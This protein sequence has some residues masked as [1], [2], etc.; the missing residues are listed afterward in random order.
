MG[1]GYSGNGGGKWAGTQPPGE[2]LGDRR[3]GWITSCFFEQTSGDG[4]IKRQACEPTKV[5]LS[6]IGRHESIQESNTAREGGGHVGQCKYADRLAG[7][8][9]QIL[10]V[11]GLGREGIDFES[12]CVTQR[13]LRLSRAGHAFCVGK[14]RVEL[15]LVHA[16]PALAQA[17]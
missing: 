12:I 10:S 9:P 5:R 13:T 16:A 11:V 3:P 2:A 14:A 1:T 8:C 6:G 15:L 17:I 4:V 7:R